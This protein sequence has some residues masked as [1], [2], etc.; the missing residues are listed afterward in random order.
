MSNFT[1]Y[2]S[3]L[4][5]SHSI[6]IL[7]TSSEFQESQQIFRCR[8]SLLIVTSQLESD[9]SFAA[10]PPTIHHDDANLE[11]HVWRIQRTGD[12]RPCVRYVFWR[13]RLPMAIVTMQ[14]SHTYGMTTFLARGVKLNKASNSHCESLSHYTM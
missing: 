4:L 6:Q 10:E 5:P 14:R 9:L 3:T 1:R 7:Y 11:L 12:R 8:F 13:G 2:I